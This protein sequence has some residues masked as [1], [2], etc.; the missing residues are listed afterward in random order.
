MINFKTKKTIKNSAENSRL[1]LGR[2][3]VNI[4]CNLI[5]VF[6]FFG[7]FNF[8][9]AA[10]VNTTDKDTLR[11]GLVGHW[12]MD[13]KDVVN[14]VLQDKSGNGN[15]GQLVNIAT[16]TFY[17]LGKIGQAFKFDGVDDSVNMGNVLNFERTDSFSF[18]AW[19]K[20]NQTGSAD[21]IITKMING[22]AY[23]G[24]MLAFSS[25]DTI[26]FYIRNNISNVAAVGTTGAFS[27]V[28]KWYHI[29]ATYNGSSLAAGM[30][31]YV[32]G[33]LVSAGAIENSLSASIVNTQPLQLAIRGTTINATS[34]P[35]NG[36]LDDVRI[37]NRALSASEIQQLYNMGR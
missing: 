26:I 19:V 4:F 18:V 27:G 34:N 25:T 13:G 22:G 23:T 10:T 7:V 33:N 3:Q 17:T 36:S 16:S 37:Y 24:Y 1:Q 12:T 14:G 9:D 29:V 11:N 2:L 28:D 6:C 8:V 15:N 30:K 20:R 5:F 21:Q 31:I 32:N 35:L